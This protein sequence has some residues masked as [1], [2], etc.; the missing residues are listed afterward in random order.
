[1][2]VAIM[3]AGAVGSFYGG[4]L[5]RAGHDVM[6]IGRQDHVSAIER[7][8]LRLE[9]QFFDESIAVPACT[10]A[11]GVAGAELVLFCVKSTNTEA[12]ACEMKPYLSDKALVLTLQNGV[13]NAQRVRD[14]VAQQ[15]SAAVV[16][17]A[18][19]MA[20]AGHVRHHGRGELI[21][22][23]GDASERI[24]R[25]M[26]AAG[27]PTDVSGNV[28]GALWEKLILN[29]AYNAISALV[30]LPFGELCR[31]G[32]ASVDKAMRDIVTECIAIAHADGVKISSNVAE[33]VQ[34]IMKTIPSGQYSSTAQD[35]SRNKHSE[36]DH[37]NG[38]IV[39]RGIVLGIPTPVNHLLLM[40]VKVLE[41]K[42][43]EVS[44]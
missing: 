18:C 41:S 14:V 43:T 24:A 28:R 17:V 27:I 21:I 33:T 36:I 10:N 44:S 20:G 8:G 39:R 31:R 30:Q 37:L 16:Y 40:L 22:E 2:K 32:G 38:L 15:V 6:L 29:C 35:L 1:M 19:Q 42:Q 5:A 26:N 7:N 11:A 25:L 23:P 12:A 4:M 9:T 13:D 34:T 3:G